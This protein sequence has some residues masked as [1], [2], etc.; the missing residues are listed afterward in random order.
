MT[1]E[2]FKTRSDFKCRAPQLPS[3]KVMF[4]KDISDSM[5]LHKAHTQKPATSWEMSSRVAIV[6]LTSAPFHQSC[7]PTS[8]E[9]AH[10]LSG[11]S[12][13]WEGSARSWAS[14]V[15]FGTLDLGNSINEQ[16]PSGVFFPI[17]SSM[18]PATSSLYW[19]PR[20]QV[21]LPFSPTSFIHCWN[22]RCRHVNEFSTI[23]HDYCLVSLTFPIQAT[24][25]L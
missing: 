19:Q 9:P 1:K 16:F 23:C 12:Q 11:Q 22:D 4:P 24:N 5:S 15:Y 2:P 10:W 6:T 7:P 17:N 25:V 3:A 20:D 14:C 13:F 21:P 8:E 18:L